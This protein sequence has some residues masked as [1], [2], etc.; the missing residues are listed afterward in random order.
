[1][2]IIETGK[3]EFF[4]HWWYRVRG[5]NLTDCGY[6]D[7]ADARHWGLNRVMRQEP[8]HYAQYAEVIK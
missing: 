2:D 3:D 7:E 5:T 4:G 6:P 8:H 1:M